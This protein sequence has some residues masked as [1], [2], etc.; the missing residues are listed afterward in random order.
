M[1]QRMYLPVLI[2]LVIISRLP[3]IVNGYGTD[4]DAWRV[5]LT[6][7]TLWETGTYEMSRFPGY[8]LYEFIQAPLIVLGGSAGANAASVLV[9]IASLFLF[10]KLLVRWNIPNTDI[11]LFAYAFLP[12]LWKNS[13]VTMDYVWGMCGLLFSLL[14]LLERRVLFAGIV[15]GLSAGIRSTNIIYLLPLLLAADWNKKR[16]PL[17]LVSSA[18]LT[19]VLCYLPVF[20]SPD[21]SAMMNEFFG[22]MNERSL[23][24][25]A[26]LIVYR[27]LFTLGLPGWGCILVIVWVNRA[28][29]SSRRQSEQMRI[30]LAVITAC[31]LMFILLPDEREYLIPCLPFLLIVIAMIAGRIQLTVTAAA[32]ISYAFVSVDIV[33]HHFG[34]PKLQWSLPAGI[35]LKEYSGREELRQQKSTLAATSI[36]DSSVV[37]IGLGPVF[38]M[39][40]PMVQRSPEMEKRF[41]QECSR[42]VSGNERYFIYA[43]KKAQLDEL[44]MKGYRIYYWERMGGYLNTFIGYTLADEHVL[45]VR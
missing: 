3:L 43:L 10:R 20:F 18:V 45:P 44:R 36:P 33:D 37:M 28:S 1:K 35:V 27:F 12:I 5:A 30:S 16:P 19:A 32:L 42:S 2:A 31:V 25:S 4:G 38:W 26:G 7:Q 8:P 22:R 11:T 15:L 23:L 24:M 17:L 29:I 40:N 34:S 14:L 9:F 41:Q 6:A 21:F 13:S 39:E